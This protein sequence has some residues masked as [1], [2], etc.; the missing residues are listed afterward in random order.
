M[1]ARMLRHIY[2]ALVPG[3]AA[4][5][6]LM[7]KGDQAKTGSGKWSK[8]AGNGLVAGKRK[9]GPFH[10]HPRRVPVAIFSRIV[11]P[12]SNYRELHCK[13]S[14]RYAAHSIKFSFIG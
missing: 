4:E 13:R 11:V 7:R 2:R 8:R 3:Y 5:T 9:S 6:G 12:S 10:Q 1:E 14:Q